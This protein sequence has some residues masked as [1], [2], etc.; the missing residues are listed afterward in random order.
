MIR[1]GWTR[2]PTSDGGL[3]PR[4]LPTGG[5]L[6]TVHVLSTGTVA[7]PTGSI[8]SNLYQPRTAHAA[9]G[10]SPDGRPDPPA[11]SA[12]GSGPSPE[13]GSGG[14]HGRCDPADAIRREKSS[15]CTG[16]QPRPGVTATRRHR[17][18]RSAGGGGVGTLSARDTRGASTAG[19]TTRRAASVRSYETSKP[20][21]GRTSEDD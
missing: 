13:P 15:Y 12:I 1:T 19:G 21:R 18:G 5:S 11:R 8:E 3:G 9:R 14:H 17:V 7:A 2:P 20:L 16:C 6:T 4:P 10:E